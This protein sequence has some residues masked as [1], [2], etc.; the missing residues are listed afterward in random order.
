MF[1]N[2]YGQDLYWITDDNGN[3]RGITVEC[4]QNLESYR[5]DKINSIM[6]K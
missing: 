2:N 3:L 1:T 6:E 5:N 4:L